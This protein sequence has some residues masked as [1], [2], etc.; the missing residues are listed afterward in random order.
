MNYR[1]EITTLPTMHDSRAA[2]VRNAIAE[3]FGVKLENLLSRDKHSDFCHRLVL[4]GRA[5]CTARN[6]KCDGCPASLVC[7]KVEV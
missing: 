3:Q 4:H 6:P 2:G 5:Y 7:K 1:I